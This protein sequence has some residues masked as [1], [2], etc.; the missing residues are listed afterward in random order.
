VGIL[1]LACLGLAACAGPQWRNADLQIDIEQ[2]GVQDTDMVRICVEGV[3]LREEPVH[4]GA[5]AFAGLPSTGLLTIRVDRLQ[6]ESRIARAG[7][8]ELGGD[9]HYR[10]VVWTECDGE[11]EPCTVEN[12]RA[13]DKDGDRLLAVRFLD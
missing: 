3:G 9:L 1:R 7:P 12:N 11:C 2:A 8:V 4:A 13:P 10:M 5:V 6:D